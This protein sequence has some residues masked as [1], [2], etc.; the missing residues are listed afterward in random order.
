MGGHDVW[1]STPVFFWK[2]VRRFNRE[3]GVV[4]H[5]PSLVEADVLDVLINQRQLPRR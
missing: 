5:V 4:L 1:A 2:V 3:E